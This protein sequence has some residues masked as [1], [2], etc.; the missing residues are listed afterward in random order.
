MCS[1]IQTRNWEQLGGMASIG[2]GRVRHA[3]AHAQVSFG[4]A[5]TQ[6]GTGSES[7]ARRYK[8][9][10]A[11]TGGFSVRCEGADA[12]LRHGQAVAPDQERRLGLDD[13]TI[14]NNDEVAGVGKGAGGTTK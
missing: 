12:E 9:T 8:L 14:A 7:L 3:P 11:D 1:R 4:V 13:R 2:S 6:S 10:Q 5:S